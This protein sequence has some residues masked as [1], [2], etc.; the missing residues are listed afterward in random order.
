MQPHMLHMVPSRGPAPPSSR[1]QRGMIPMP[2]NTLLL[3]LQQLLLLLLLLQALGLPAP[4]IAPA[5]LQQLPHQFVNSSQAF[6]HGETP[7]YKCIRIPSIVAAPLQGRLLAFAAGRRWY[8]DGC[9]PV[10]AF[11]AA[12]GSCTNSSRPQVARPV[13]AAVPCDTD[14]VMKTS[15][16]AGARG[17]THTQARSLGACMDEAVGGARVLVSVFSCMTLPAAMPTVHL[18]LLDAELQQTAIGTALNYA[19]LQGRAGARLSWRLSAWAA[20]TRWSR[21]PVSSCSTTTTAPPTGC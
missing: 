9:C 21:A 10:A 19:T 20:P 12:G 16:D 8:G 14:L 3:L 5:A 4:V 13:A 18:K 15:T 6:V 2:S 11:G 7:E 17:H 1:Q